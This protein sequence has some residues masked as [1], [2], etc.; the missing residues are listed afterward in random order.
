MPHVNYS[1]FKLVRSVTY[2][3]VRVHVHVQFLFLFVFMFMLRLHE[4][5]QGNGRGHVNKICA[6]KFLCTT[7]RALKG[8]SAFKVS[9][10]VFSPYF[11]ST[12][13]VLFGKLFLKSSILYLYCKSLSI[14]HTY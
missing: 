6:L 14:L 4:H 10:E 12:N 7:V 5:G 8:P 3:H 11:Y 2:V 9:A 1:F 13:Y